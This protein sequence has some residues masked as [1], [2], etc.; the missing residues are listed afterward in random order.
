MS[1]L[2]VDIV[3]VF[4]RL[5]GQ[6]KDNVGKPQSS[7]FPRFQDKEGRSRKDRTTKEQARQAGGKQANETTVNSVVF[8]FVLE[9]TN[10]LFFFFSFEVLWSE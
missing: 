8:V 6:K 3:V 10:R 9:R 5:T 4:N 2:E 7:V 1:P